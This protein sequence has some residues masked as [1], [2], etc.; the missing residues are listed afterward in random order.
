[1][2]SLP[3]KSSSWLSSLDAFKFGN[4]TYPRH[5]RRRS[6]FGH[7]FQGKKVHLWARK[8]GIFSSC[9][10]YIVIHRHVN[11]ILFLYVEYHATDSFMKKYYCIFTVF[12]TIALF[13]SLSHFC[14]RYTKSHIPS[15]AAL[16]FLFAKWVASL[17]CASHW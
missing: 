9:M 4:N 6:N 2:L 7:I 11:E 15:F 17:C 10:T 16:L 12:Y 14:R 5:I 3:L 13:C 1:M 8:Y